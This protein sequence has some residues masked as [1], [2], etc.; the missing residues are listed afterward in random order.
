MQ[1]CHND[2]MDEWSIEDTIYLIMMLIDS[3]LLV[4]VTTTGYYWDDEGFNSHN[5]MFPSRYR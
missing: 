3:K 2:L 1:E 5:A 4:P